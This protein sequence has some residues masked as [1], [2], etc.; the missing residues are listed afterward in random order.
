M[1][2]VALC[3]S[4]ELRFFLF[5]LKIKMIIPAMM[6]TPAAP[7]TTTPAI[8]PV[9][10]EEE[11]S[12]PVTTG[13]CVSGVKALTELTQNHLFTSSTCASFVSSKKE[14]CLFV[15]RAPNRMIK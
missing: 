12:G 11:P 14:V 5:R 13:D 3:S 10:T 8:I 9:L 15:L 1:L 2:L 4:S 7:P 6:A